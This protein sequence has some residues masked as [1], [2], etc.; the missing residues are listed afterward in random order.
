VHLHVGLD[1]VVHLVAGVGE[2]ARQR[3]D[4]ADLHR[5]LRVRRAERRG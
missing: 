1:A 5:L 2:L 3:H 4:H